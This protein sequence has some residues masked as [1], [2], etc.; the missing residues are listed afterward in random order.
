MLAAGEFFEGLGEIEA[1][2]G[3]GDIERSLQIDGTRAGPQSTFEKRTRPIHDHLGGIEIVLGTQTVAG[4]TRAVGRI[5]A[6][7]AGLKLRD[8]DAAFGAGQL[9][10]EDLLGAV[11]HRNGYQALGELERRVQRLGQTRG[12]AGLHQQAVDDDFNIV[13]L[14]A[15]EAGRL[16]KRIKHA[17]DAHARVSGARQFIELLAVFA[18]A[19][20]NDGREHHDAIAFMG[21][22]AAQDS[23]NDLFAGLP[24]DGAAAV[25]TMRHADGAIDDAKI[26]VNFRDGA[27]GGSRRARGGFLL[28]GDGGREAVDGIDVRDAPSGRETGAR[29]RKGIRRSGAGPRRRWCQRRARIC[30]IRIIP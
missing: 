8:G 17:I 7:G 19:A 23:L 15:I 4:G 16:V 11:H 29:K 12:D 9:F 27:H 22:F 13:I 25:G 5:E 24:G 30:P 14:A 21:Q 6:E 10:R 26:I 2:S 18:L 28:D 1:V 20:A 3:G